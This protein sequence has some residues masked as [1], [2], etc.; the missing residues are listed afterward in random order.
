MQVKANADEYKLSDK[1]ADLA[2][3]ADRGDGVTV[4]DALAIQKYLA[5]TI[6]KL[7]LE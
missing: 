7:P 6:D 4:A 5:G 3:V 2:D 1:G